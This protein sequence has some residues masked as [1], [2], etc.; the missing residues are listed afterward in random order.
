MAA[1]VPPPVA[2]WGA[3]ASPGAI[4]IAPSSRSS[5]PSPRRDLAT[6][7]LSFA[8]AVL[9]WAA[10]ATWW[11]S[12]GSAVFYL[13]YACGVWASSCVPYNDFS[14][15]TI[16]RFPPQQYGP[17]GQSTPANNVAFVN[18]QGACACLVLAGLIMAGVSA[19]AAW[20]AL[21]PAALSSGLPA[22]LPTRLATATVA[23]FVLAI[24]GVSLP[25]TAISLSAGVPL[26]GP[27]MGIAVAAVSLCGIVWVLLG[28]GGCCYAC[29][30]PV[31][32][33]QEPAA[34]GRVDAVAKSAPVLATTTAV[35]IDTGVTIPVT[36]TTATCV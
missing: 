24:M 11:A 4:N 25:S 36:S 16:N 10:S 23:A 33:A 3:I 30:G 34:R 35:T 18:L 12:S 6:A 13:A 22:W 8:A 19:V 29:H 21:A 14:D 27:G 31:P 28:I 17:V 15:P 1:P 20:R 5:A 7:F 26:N 32:S 9:C 2:S